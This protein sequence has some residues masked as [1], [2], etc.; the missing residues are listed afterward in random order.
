M[1]YGLHT[2]HSVGIILKEI[3]RRAIVVARNHLMTFQV[4]AKVGYD[5][6]SE[7]FFTNADQEA[8]ALIVKLL[9]ENFPEYGIIGEEGGEYYFP[10]NAKGY[11]TIDPIDGTKAYMRRQSHGVSVMIAMVQFQLDGKRTVEAVY[12][13]DVNTHEI[14]G[15]RPGS[16]KVHRISEYEVS[17]VLPSAPTSQLF[18]GYALLRDPVTRFKSFPLVRR[19]TER[20]ANYLVDGS[21]IGTWFTRLWKGEVA[22]LLMPPGFETPWDGTPCV[23]ISGKLRYQYFRPSDDRSR[24]MEYW[25]KLL[26]KSETRDFD[27]LVIHRD[28]AV[29]L[30]GVMV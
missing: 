3:V 17:E 11:F 8:Q 28:H 2:D 23:G 4:S 9:K 18:A 14:F 6:T 27:T 26:Q 15:Y 20:F 16:H 5:G 21:S 19:T 7:D 12:I 25:P 22:A 10:L 1:Q 29:H 30:N 13:G 24:W